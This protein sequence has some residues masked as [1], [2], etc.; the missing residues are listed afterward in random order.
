M[1]ESAIMYDAADPA[2]IPAGPPDAI[3]AGYLN[4]GDPLKPWKLKD[5]ERFGKRRKLPI[6]VRSDPAG[7]SEAEADAFAALRNLYDLGADA[8]CLVA[9]D[10][11][12][13]RDPAYVTRF[14]AVLNHYL[15]RVLPY[16]SRTNLLALPKLDGRWLAAPD[17]RLSDWPRGDDVRLI[18]NVNGDGFDQSDV[19]H[20][21][22]EFGDWWR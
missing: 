20:W 3:V 5:W 2:K 7:G 13:A 4:P 16:G 12:T 22:S 14:G 6:L 9:L 21:L 15:Y 18:Q 11:E 17:S 10:I 1:I 19:R 8:P